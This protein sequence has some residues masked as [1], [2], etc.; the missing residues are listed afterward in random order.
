MGLDA[1]ISLFPAMNPD[2]LRAGVGRFME[3]G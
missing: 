2:E 1:K 3:M